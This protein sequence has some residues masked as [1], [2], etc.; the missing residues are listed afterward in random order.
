MEPKIIAVVVTYNFDNSIVQNLKAISDE[1]S[2]LVIDNSTKEESKKQIC[3]LMR[4]FPHV[5]FIRN[6]SNIGLA[7]AYNQAVEYAKE[8]KADYFVTFDQDTFIKKGTIKEL[9]DLMNKYDL[10]SIGPSYGTRQNDKNEIAHCNFL[11]SSCNISRMKVYEHIRYDESLFIDNVDV[12]FC[13]SLKKYG[14]KFARATRIFVDHALG[15]KYQGRFGISFK[16]HSPFRY[17]YIFR[18]YFILRK[19]HN[20]NYLRKIHI[21]LILD[22][23]VIILFFKR[24]DRKDALHYIKTGYS[25]GKNI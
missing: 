13:L 11:I 12:D 10:D 22:F 2:L 19:K 20:D 15:E 6:N 16:A 7:K 25:E 4:V 14:Y 17:Y 24:N 1:C 23:V 3:E 21:R 18:N 8:D 5:R 9:I